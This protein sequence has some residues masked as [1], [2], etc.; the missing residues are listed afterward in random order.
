[1]DIMIIGLPHYADLFAADWLVDQRYTVG[2][3]RRRGLRV[4]FLY[5]A[6]F[7]GLA[8]L[9]KAVVEAKPGLIFFDLNEENQGNVLR[10]IKK[11]RRALPRVLI[12]AG[13]IIPATQP[14]FFLQ[15]HRQVD[16]VLRGERELVLLAAARALRS[17]NR[18]LRKV[19]GLTRRRFHNPPAPALSDLDQLGFMADDGLAKLIMA[20]DQ[21]T[22]YI[23]TSRGCYGNCSFCGVPSLYRQS[24]G[25]AWRGRSA[26]AIVSEL[27]L[28]TK[29]FGLKYFVFQDDNFTG[30]G[31][32]GRQRVQAI[33]REMIR[34]QLKV[35]FSACCRLNDLDAP[36][37]R[38]LKKAG[39]DRLCVSLEALN[40]RSLDLFNKGLKA[41]MIR[42]AL[43]L[44]EKLGINT[45]INL[46]FF[47]PYMSLADVQ[48]NLAF[49]K[50]LRQ[51]R[52]LFYS[53][54]FPF[55]ELKPFAWSPVAARLRRDDLLD[56]KTMTCRYRDPAVGKLVALTRT[57]RCSSVYNFKLRLLFRRLAAL[58]ALKNE[59][60]LLAELETIARGFRYLLG[61]ELLPDLLTKACRIIGRSGPAAGPKLAGLK[62]S[63][64][65]KVRT[66]ERTLDRQVHD[67]LAASQA[68]SSSR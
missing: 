57:L 59:P 35:K 19:A 23:M 25:P 12:M 38:L 3:L 28:L 62:Q 60:G 2:F 45:E 40:Q 13:G 6:M 54:A 50:Q 33:A 49:L 11:V 7:S 51:R 41:R 27:R 8:D 15:H 68:I 30:P 46:I 61:L 34:R 31:S 24:V 44:L 64:Q 14:D 29:Q 4:G 67:H 65:R 9:V 53:N 58:P 37:L 47:E 5:P 39:L 42:P 56:E 43:A 63:F 48:K 21:P 22:G 66:F 32:A 16:Y 52:H 55:N 36:T 10:L 1:M 26:R 20:Q 18:S 17:K